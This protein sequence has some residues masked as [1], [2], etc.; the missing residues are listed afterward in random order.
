MGQ[1][2]KYG[3]SNLENVDS[4]EYFG[5]KLKYNT[6]VSHLMADRASK[7]RRVTH[8]VMQAISTNDKNISPRLSLNLFDKQIMPILNY[9]AAVCSVPRLYNLIYL[10]NQ[11]GKNTRQLVSTLFNDICG[12][13]IP[14]VYA[15]RVGKITE[16]DTV[17]QRKILIKLVSYS[18]KELLLRDYSHIFSIYEDKN[19]IEKVHQYFCKRTLNVSTYASKNVVNAELDRCPIMHKAWG[20]AIKYWLRLENGTENAILNEA[21]LEAKT[22]NHDWIQSV[23]YML[24]TN[25]FRDIWLNPLNCNEQTFHKMFIQRLDDQYRQNLLGFIKTSRFQ[26]L[27]SLKDGVE[28][29]PYITQIRNPDIR[30]IFTRLRIDLNCLVTCKTKKTLIQRDTCP[31]CHIDGESVEIFLLVCTHF[32]KLRIDFENSIRNVFYSY[33]NLSLNSKLKYILDLHCP[34]GGSIELL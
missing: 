8:M 32:D 22:A 6:A 26:V 1:P 23:Q 34:P 2:I 29:S 12:I 31:F 18:Q 16:G 21:F 7:A 27:S 25:G 10:H 5:F 30:Q 24:C 28:L 19:E 11:T 15:K 13:K 20:L 33:D 9:G 4:F 17:D 3:E 14:F